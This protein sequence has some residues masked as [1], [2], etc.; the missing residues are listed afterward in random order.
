ML[1][2]ALFI[3]KFIYGKLIKYIKMKMFKNNNNNVVVS[4]KGGLG[5]GGMVKIT[6]SDVDDV[7]TKEGNNGQELREPPL[8]IRLTSVGNEYRRRRSSTRVHCK[9]HVRRIVSDC[10]RAKR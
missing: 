10:R 8:E 2:V 1:C 5:E 9:R 4:Q 7:V 3:Q 6:E